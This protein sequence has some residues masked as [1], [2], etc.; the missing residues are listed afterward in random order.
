[1]TAPPG[2]LHVAAGV[3]DDGAG[4]VLIARR[5]AHR[6]Q[7]GLWEFPGGKVE[8]GETVRAALDRELHEELG[9][10]VRS[11]RPLIRIPHA[12]H[13]RRVL[14]DVWRVTSFAD[15]PHGRE[16]Q[17]LRWVEAGALS[18]YEFPAAN[19]PIVTA[20][21]L[22][23]RY[24][25]TPEPGPSAQWPEFLHHLARRLEAGIRLV[26]LRAKTLAPPQCL[27]LA[28]QAVEI[29]RY[30]GATLLL[31]GSPELAGQVGADGVHLDGTWL[32]AL[33]RRP[34][35]PSAW[36]AASCHDRAQLARAE[37]LGVDF[38]VLSPVLATVSHPQAR[39]IGWEGLRELTES[40]GLPAF[41]LGGVGPGDLA[42]AWRHG[43]QGV[44]AIRGL[45]G[46]L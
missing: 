22:P 18:G 2:Y 33:E 23:E 26:Q 8:P 7:G 10:Q 30:H 6:H 46:E 12:Y 5:A 31:N 21:R 19:R 1:M 40:T 43:A 38:V 29:A 39:P 13:D 14:L 3:I 20:A 27:D 28:R 4:R 15:E 32:A 16:G 41:A 25:I 11:A 37:A 42:Q 17:P 44:A 24:L 36:V 45:W 35:P 9:I 34:L